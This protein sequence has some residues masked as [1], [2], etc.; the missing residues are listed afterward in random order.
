MRLR[1][2]VARRIAKIAPK[3]GAHIYSSTSTESH[4]PTVNL[5][6]HVKAIQGLHIVAPATSLWDCLSFCHTQSILHDYTPSEA[7]MV[8]WLQL[9]GSGKHL[10]FM[11][12]P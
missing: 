10:C 8:S 5:T 11:G 6:K 3:P 2:A 7:Y 12:F 4:M 1:H 9:N